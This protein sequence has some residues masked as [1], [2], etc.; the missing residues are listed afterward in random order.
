LTKFWSLN[1]MEGE[2][3]LGEEPR[4]VVVAGQYQPTTEVTG[5]ERVFRSLTFMVYTSDSTD[6]SAP[7]INDVTAS[8]IGGEF[9][10]EADV[11]DSGTGVQAVWVTYE[12]TPGHWASAKLNYHW[13]TSLWTG[14]VTSALAEFDYFVQAVDWAGNTSMSSNKGLYFSAAPVE[15][16]LPIILR[17]TVR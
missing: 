11:S 4:L 2:D 7:A 14:T 15:V 17:N 9:A 5:T 1:T 3:A 8:G 13:A 16:Y 6:A 10:I 12:D